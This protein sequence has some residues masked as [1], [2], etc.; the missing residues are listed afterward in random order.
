[1]SETLLPYDQW[2][3]GAL[4]S[5]IRQALVETAEHGLPGN[6]HFY[7]T[8]KTTTEGVEMAP[9]LRAT[10]P[11]QMTIVLQHQF[12]DLLVDE[13]AMAVTLKFRGKPERLRVPFC[14]IVAFAD[15]SVNFGLQFKMLSAADDA[16]AAATEQPAEAAANGGDER[17]D[18]DDAARSGEVIA[19]DTF[20]KK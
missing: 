8:F 11:E 13:D 1:M 10:H 9:A 3:D 5:V 16:E 12:R 4:R 18:A 20:R 7:I 17:E 2:I 15:P 6:H 14:A 19:L